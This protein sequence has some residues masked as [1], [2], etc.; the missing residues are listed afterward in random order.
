VPSRTLTY[1][2]A[3]HVPPYRVAA[4]GRL[5]RLAE[6]GGP[7]LGLID[8][9]SYEVGE[10]R[11]DPGD[12]VAIVTDGVTEAM[13]PDDSEFGDERACEALL[14]LSR[15]SAS[16]VLRGL[17]VAVDAWAGAAGFSDDLTALVLKA[18]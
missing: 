5:S 13:S 12:L 7:A 3:G 18:R 10:V 14:A 9:A 4:G 8:E 17:V 15:G 1:V 2:N 11:L 16:D 6:G